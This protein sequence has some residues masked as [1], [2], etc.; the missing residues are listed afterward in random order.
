MF[1]I[2]SLLPEDLSHI[3]SH[4]VLTYSSD[5][6]SFV[7]EARLCVQCDHL[8]RNRQQESIPVRCVPPAC[9]PY[10]RSHV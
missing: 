6:N 4:I 3:I 8:V 10:P 2:N 5:S 1:D 9:Q 7:T